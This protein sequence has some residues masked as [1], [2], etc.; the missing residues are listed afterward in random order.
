M[1]SAEN[2][3]N[4]RYFLEKVKKIAKVEKISTIIIP[5]SS[6]RS[7][8]EAMKI[9]KD[10]KLVVVTKCTGA[11]QENLNE[12]SEEVRNELN[13]R[14]IPIITATHPFG[15]IGRAIRNKYS[16]FQID[17][18]MAS[19]LRIFGDGVKVAIEVSMMATDA[20]CIKTNEK[21]ISLGGK[22][23]GIDKGLILYPKNTH[24]FFDI[25]VEKIIE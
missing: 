2:M 24:N 12:L 21:I 3:I 14:G 16:S 13:D 10:F 25:K 15:G 17:E 23:C 19:T 18:L 5:S 8:C 4:T 20:G 9:F 11:K 22:K 6:G 1:N 7:A